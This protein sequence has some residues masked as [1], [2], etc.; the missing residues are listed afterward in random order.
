MISETSD[1]DWPV[2]RDLPL[3]DPADVA[4]SEHRPHLGALPDLG[5]NRWRGVCSSGEVLGVAVAHGCT[6]LLG[7]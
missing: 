1:C 5:A 4:L 7:V 3:G 2:R 6:A